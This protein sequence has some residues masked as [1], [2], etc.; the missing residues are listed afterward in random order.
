MPES[1]S[2]SLVDI[3]CPGATVTILTPQGCHLRGRAV[4]PCSAGGWVLNGGGRH[5]TPLIADD[6]NIVSVT[7]PRER[8][9]STVLSAVE[10]LQLPK[11][12]PTP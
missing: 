2:E 7:F 8:Q 10:L 12:E 5:G 6:T 1:E 4:M 3:I 11:H 9:Q